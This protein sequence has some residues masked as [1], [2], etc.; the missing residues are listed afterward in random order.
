LVKRYEKIARKR[1]G[2]PPSRGKCENAWEGTP[3]NNQR[4]GG[5]LTI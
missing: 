4:P 5:K 2:I 3:E 1:K